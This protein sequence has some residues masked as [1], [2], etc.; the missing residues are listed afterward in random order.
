VGHILDAEGNLAEP[1]IAAN[2]KLREIAEVHDVWLTVAP[3]K[4]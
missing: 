4:S 3:P 2:H 1:A